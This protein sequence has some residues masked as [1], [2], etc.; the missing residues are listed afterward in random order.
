M[1]RGDRHTVATGQAERIHM[2]AAQSVGRTQPIRFSPKPE[3]GAPAVR[4]DPD[5][6]VRCQGQGAHRGGP[7]GRI[8]PERIAVQAFAPDHGA[9][10]QCRQYATVRSTYRC[11]GIIVSAQCGIGAVTI[12][13][14]KAARATKPEQAEAVLGHT[15]DLYALLAIPYGNG[16]RERILTT[17]RPGDQ[18]HQHKKHPGPHRWAGASKRR[19]TSTRVTGASF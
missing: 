10:G 15:A 14:E 12:G 7:Q 8:R 13:T 17:R 3:H 2:V 6:V 4:A 9:A 5:P 16:P 19:S 1:I 18:H 11:Y